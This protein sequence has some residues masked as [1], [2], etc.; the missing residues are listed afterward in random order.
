MEGFEVKTITNNDLR[1]YNEPS[2]SYLGTLFEGIKENWPEMS[3]NDIWNYL[4][5]C[6]R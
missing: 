4:G 3:E 2:Q 6:M 1:P 5:N